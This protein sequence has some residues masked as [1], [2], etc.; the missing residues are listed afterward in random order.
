MNDKG[1]LGIYSWQFDS[2]WNF[3]A[4]DN[5]SGDTLFGAFAAEGAILKG[6]D[7]ESVVSPLSRGDMSNW[8]GL[9][10]GLPDTLARFLED[11][12]MDVENSTFCCWWTLSAPVWAQGPVSFPND[13]DD[14]SEYLLDYLHYEP[15]N[16]LAWARGYYEQPFELADV[17]A[18]YGFRFSTQLI[19]RLNPQAN[20]DAVRK[21]LLKLKMTE[22][23]E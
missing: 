10:E 14:G 15:E 3:G 16:H 4:I 17:E 9:F 19:R 12:A 21:G 20:L 6:F 7:H 1:W 5:G 2:G 11:P 22:G 18:L 13:E 8:P 23:N